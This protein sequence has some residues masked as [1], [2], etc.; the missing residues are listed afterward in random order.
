[1]EVIFIMKIIIRVNVNKNICPLRYT[2]D[3]GNY[4][5]KYPFNPNDL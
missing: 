1:M 3:Y 5:E 4:T 2:D